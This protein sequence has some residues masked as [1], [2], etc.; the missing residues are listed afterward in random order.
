MFSTL[1][2]DSVLFSRYFGRR[3]VC[4]VRVKSWWFPTRLIIIENRI[5]FIFLF[6]NFLYILGFFYRYFVCHQPPLAPGKSQWRWFAYAYAPLFCCS[7]SY[8]LWNSFWY[9]SFKYFWD[10]SVSL[11][12]FWRPPWV[13]GQSERLVMTQQPILE[14]GEKIRSGTKDNNFDNTET[15]WIKKHWFIQIF[16]H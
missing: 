16:M 11:K 7:L 1:Y 12:I 8:H 4:L 9:F 13:P 10:T 15:P 14:K 5:W 6:E 2:G 3:P